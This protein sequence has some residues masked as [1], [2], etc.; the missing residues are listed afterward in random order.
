MVG[1]GTSL[2]TNHCLLSSALRQICLWAVFANRGVG[3]VPSP[4]RISEKF[5]KFAKS[6][7][8][9]KIL[10]CLSYSEW[11]E[12]YKNGNFFDVGSSI[13]PLDPPQ[14]IPPPVDLPGGRFIGDPWRL[15]FIQNIRVR[16][17]LASRLENP[18]SQ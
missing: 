5:T 10:F 8:F 7:P 16:F 15:R 3:V 2:I 12:L 14:L 17:F 4:W 13:D 11:S 6:R 9:F 1:Y 18:F